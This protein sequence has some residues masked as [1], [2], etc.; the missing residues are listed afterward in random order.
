MLLLKIF[1]KA[2]VIWWA[3][4]INFWEYSLGYSYLMGYYYLIGKNLSICLK[5]QIVV[6]GL[7]FKVYPPNL[8]KIHFSLSFWN[9]DMYF[10]YDNSNGVRFRKM[11]M[12]S[13][14]S[15]SWIVVLFMA[16]TF[17]ISWNLRWLHLLERQRF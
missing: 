12:G 4:I 10:C 14:L 3:T 17:G 15:I 5:L 16:N 2:M 6:A 1:P 13:A 8:V 9:A 7:L 11:S